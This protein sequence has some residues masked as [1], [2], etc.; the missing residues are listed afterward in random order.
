[1]GGESESSSQLS[2]RQSRPRLG[3][4]PLSQPRKH[5]PL[6]QSSSL[7]AHIPTLPFSRLSHRTAAVPIF[8]PPTCVATQFCTL[9]QLIGFRDQALALFLFLL[10]TF[11]TPR[12][13]P[14]FDY[15]S[16]FFFSL[17]LSMASTRQPKPTRGGKGPTG[18]AQCV[19][20]T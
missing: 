2:Q 8:R 16:F 14:A 4:P 12:Q 6:A 5:F 17:F 11:I 3:R 18:P 20:P 19:S 10:P 15:L 9:T 13:S 1:M 7:Q